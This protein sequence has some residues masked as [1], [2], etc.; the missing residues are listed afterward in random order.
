MSAGGR[1]GIPVVLLGR[2]GSPRATL[3]H[4]RHIHQT[5]E[6]YHWVTAVELSEVLRRWKY[7]Y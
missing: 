6:K 4:G 2:V 3:Q 1:Y 5:C 7:G